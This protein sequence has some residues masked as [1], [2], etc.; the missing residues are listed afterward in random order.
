MANYLTFDKVMEEMNVDDSDWGDSDDDL[1]QDELDCRL[2]NQSRQQDDEDPLDRIG[3]SQEDDMPEV[4]ESICEQSP[5]TG[6]ET[7]TF[8]P[9]AS[10]VF[11]PVPGPR[12]SVLV[13]LNAESQPYD[14]FC[15]IWGDDTF[16]LL[17]D[18]T[19]RYAAQKETEGWEDVSAEEM[20]SFIG[21][22]LAM[23]MVRLPSMYDYWSTNPILSAPGIVKGMGR[24]RFRSILSHLHLN[25]NSRMPGRT[26]PGYDKLYKVRPLLEK[27]RLNSQASYQPHQQLAVDEAMI[28]FK[29]RSVMKQYLP[30]KPIKRGYKMWCLCDSSNGYMYNMSL[31][32]GA[33]DSSNEDSL[34]SRVVQHLVQPLYNANHHIYMDNYFSSIALATKL[35]ENNTYTIGTVRT[36]RKHWPVEYKNV[37]LISKSMQRGESKS[38]VV[39]GVQCIVWK[40]NKGVAF[41]NNVTDPTNL[42][43]V[44]RRNKDGTRSQVPCPEAVKLYNKYM[45]GVD[46]FDSRRKTYSCTRKSKKWWM[47]IYYFLLNTAITN[48]YICERI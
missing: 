47:R 20:Q 3:E 16:D 4:D 11:L 35:A 5:Q 18:E 39:A 13:D 28:L 31:Y 38:K 41:L 23:G 19:N 42:S 44:P 27:I 17:A 32:T 1:I 37:K 33:D 21:I 24:N 12:R 45:G 26:D 14:F 10:D 30:L 6:D 29:G 25:D 40:D 9:S 46:V 22:Q 2:D 34:S 36:N 7:A 48:A 43:Q 15:K 8:H